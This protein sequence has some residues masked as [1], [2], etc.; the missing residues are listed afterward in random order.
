MFNKFTC[1]NFHF[2]LS[3]FF[4]VVSA[5]QMYIALHFNQICMD[6]SDSESC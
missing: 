4:G 3:G 2:F 1:L 6:G 5:I